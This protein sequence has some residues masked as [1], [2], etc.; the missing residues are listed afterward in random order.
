MNT[1]RL[2]LASVLAV[3]TTFPAHASLHK[4]CDDANIASSI[5][6]ALDAYP[7]LGGLSSIQVQAIG[8]VVYLH[9][10]VDTYPEKE[11]VQSVA[12]RT[13]GVERV[14]NSIELQNE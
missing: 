7:Q 11:L 1:S 2:L 12:E 6:S 8:H 4:M 5:D 3:A 9:G 10:L 13:P 14:V